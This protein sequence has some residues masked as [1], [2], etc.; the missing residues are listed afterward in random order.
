M[1]V[2][3]TR[4]RT[5]SGQ[6]V[7][8]LETRIAALETALTSGARVLSGLLAAESI[9]VG[10]PVMLA[11]GGVYRARATTSESIVLGVAKTAAASGAALDIY[12]GGVIP[13]LFGSAP[14]A[15][16]K[17]AL[18][19]LSST[20][21]RADTSPPSLGS[22]VAWVT[23]GIIVGADGSTTSPTVRFAPSVPL[24]GA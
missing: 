15:S 13:V 16:T 22:G 6:S 19:Y 20:A 11:S 7:D 18:C 14:A 24:Y 3:P 2:G 23:L 9:A 17:G 12:L 21:G 1:S 5:R 4:T 8:D 10:E